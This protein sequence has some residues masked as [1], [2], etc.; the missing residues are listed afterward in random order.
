MTD[1]D[2]VEAALVFAGPMLDKAPLSLIGSKMQLNAIS[3]DTL[4]DVRAAVDAQIATIEN[5]EDYREAVRSFR[6][7]SMPRFTGR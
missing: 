6:A 1:G 3:T 4:G 2:A 7:K 5:S